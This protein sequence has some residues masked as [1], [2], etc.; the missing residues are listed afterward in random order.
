MLADD[1]KGPSEEAWI[2]TLVF[3]SF[4][5]AMK[6]AANRVFGG[7]LRLLGIR[8]DPGEGDDGSPR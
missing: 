5:G 7:F 8:R 1:R 4:I 6:R 2:G 3:L